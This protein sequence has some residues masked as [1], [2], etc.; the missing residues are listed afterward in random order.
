MEIRSKKVFITGLGGFTGYHLT[1]YLLEHNYEVI[2]IG[3]NKL[4]PISSCHFINLLDKEKLIELLV[5]EEPDYIIHLAGISFVGHDNKLDFY[6]VNT[7]G[8]EN[9]LEAIINSNIIPQKVILAS[10][11]TIYGN[12]SEYI[13]HENITPN[14]VNHYG[15]SKLAMEFIAKTYF[16]KLP[17]IITRPFNYTGVGHSENFVIP[18]IIKHFKDKKMSIELG[19]IYTLREYNDVDWVCSVYCKLMVSNVTDEIV[20][21][22]S[23][24]S[25]SI[26]EILSIAT[27]ISGHKL[28]VSINS[29]FVRN[30]EIQ[31]LKGSDKKLISMIGT[32]NSENNDLRKLITK[33]I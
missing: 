7:I 11:A 1:A 25:H 3:E 27:E 33:M 12:Q 14:P 6:Q 20:N 29:K 28:E 30:N 5:R 13:L 21:I 4:L 2:G 18:K 32:D 26:N 15:I 23:N 22:C 19:N 24:K 10:S 16:N 31:E 17:I 9:L 8:T